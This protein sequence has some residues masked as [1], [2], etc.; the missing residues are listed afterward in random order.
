MGDINSCMLVEELEISDF[1]SFDSDPLREDSQDLPS[2]ELD[3]LKEVQTLAW[4]RHTKAA[5]IEITI[6][7]LIC[8]LGS[9]AYCQ[10]FKRFNRKR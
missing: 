6:A 4:L 9:R 10:V 1:S 8:S 3:L 2:C 5:R 7:R